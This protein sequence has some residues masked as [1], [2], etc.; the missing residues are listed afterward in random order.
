MSIEAW[1]HQACQDRWRQDSEHQRAIDTIQSVLED[2]TASN[3]AASTIA[4]LYEP[5]IKRGTLCVPTLWG[6]FCDAARVLG[7]KQENSERLVDLLNS[8]SGLPD[9]KTAEGNP[10]T[11]AWSSAGVYWRDL[12]EFT[13]IFREYGIGKSKIIDF[14]PSRITRFALPRQ[15]RQISD[16]PEKTRHPARRRPGSRRKMGRSSPPSPQRHHLRRHKFPPRQKRTRHAL[17][18]RNQSHA[19]HRDTLSPPGPVAPSINVRPARGDLDHFRRPQDPWAL[20]ERL[21]SPERREGLHAR[22]RGVL[23]GSGTRIQ[24]GKVGVLEEEVWRDCCY[25]GLGGSC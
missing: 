4:A 22:G 7:G 25:K 15:A 9:V 17:P 11:P 12:P 10:M 13:M 8:I 2:K 6:I 3:D 23:V 14:F 1:A 16:S 20:R 18:H 24:F 21:R 5:L 19:R